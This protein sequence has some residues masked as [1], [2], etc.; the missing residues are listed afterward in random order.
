MPFHLIRLCKACLFIR[1]TNTTMNAFTTLKKIAILSTMA[2]IFLGSVTLSWAQEGDVELKRILV[3]YS[4]HEGFR[5][6]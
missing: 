4:Y 6:R 1:Q 2:H 3:I 5:N